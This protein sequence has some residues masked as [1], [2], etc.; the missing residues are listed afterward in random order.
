[1]LPLAGRLCQPMLD[2]IV[3]NVIAMGI[4][5]H[6]VANAV[7]PELLLSDAFLSLPEQRR[8]NPVD[9]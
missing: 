6:V 7:F 1:V 5:V 9:W 8:W 2:R 4:E 3:V